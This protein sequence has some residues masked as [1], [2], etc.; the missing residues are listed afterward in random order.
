LRPLSGLP[1]GDDPWN[2]WYDKAFGFVVC[3]ETEVAA[4][5]LADENAG[6]ENRTEFL[7]R[8]ISDTEHPWLDAKYSTCTLLEP[9]GNPRIIL[10]D[11]ASA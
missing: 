3:A 5:Q 4:R 2:L 10:K 6:D 11:F 8:K 1:K 7:G 9:T